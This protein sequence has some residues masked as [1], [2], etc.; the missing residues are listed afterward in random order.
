VQFFE[1]PDLLLGLFIVTSSIVV[2]VAGVCIIRCRVHYSIL[3]EDHEVAGFLYSMVGVIYAV[4][5][6][7]ITIVVWEQYRDAQNYVQQEAVRV[8]NLLRDAQ[9]FP[10]PVRK[11]LRGKLLAYG[12]AVVSDEWNTMAKRQPSPLA[13][14]AYEDIWETIYEIQPETERERAFYRESITRLNEL[15]GIR[16][17]RLLSSQSRIPSLLWVLLAGGAAISIAY[18]YMFGM[19]NRWVHVLTAGSLAGLIGFVLF[20]ILALSSPFSGSL[21]ISPDPLESVLQLWEH[22]V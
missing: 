14:K 3:K 5:L 8:S 7:F 11:K 18:T 17:S 15:S 16:R 22:T 1:V 6:A 2:A 9:V 12:R 10:D 4:L 20:L 13:S 21:L 19:K